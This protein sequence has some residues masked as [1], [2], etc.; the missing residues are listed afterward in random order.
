[1][2]CL[3]S[4]HFSILPLT[5]ALLALCRQGKVEC[6]CCV[7][8]RVFSDPVEIDLAALCQDVRA[9]GWEA[10]NWSCGKDEGDV[11]A[12]LAQ[13]CSVTQRGRGLL[14]EGRGGGVGLGERT[15]AIGLAGGLGLYL[16]LPG[17]FRSRWIMTDSGGRL[18]FP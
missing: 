5:E 2:R 16:L 4:N 18:G 12:W 10:G 17:Y 6:G 8:S 11:G 14:S 1:M 15:K 7:D 3:C 9:S 13:I